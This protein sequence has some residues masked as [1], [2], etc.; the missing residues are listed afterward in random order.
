[1]ATKSKVEKRVEIPAVQLQDKSSEKNTPSRST[2]GSLN[3]T[4]F[5]WDQT[6]QMYG[7]LEGFPL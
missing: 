5:G 4:H 6:M 3:G 1:M 2:R 7:N